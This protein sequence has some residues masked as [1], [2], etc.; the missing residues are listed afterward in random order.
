MQKMLENL[1]NN[2]VAVLTELAIHRG[3]YR[4]KKDDF[5]YRIYY[6]IAEELLDELTERGE[7]KKWM[8]TLLGEFIEAQLKTEKLE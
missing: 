8:G 2:Q 3:M 1:T 6:K 4:Y 7:P 5:R